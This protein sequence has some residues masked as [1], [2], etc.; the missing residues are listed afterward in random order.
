M[1]P[2]KNTVTWA[3]RLLLL[4]AP[5]ISSEG[6]AAPFSP[7]TLPGQ[8]IYQSDS[9]WDTTEGKKILLS[10]LKGAPVVVAM[11]YTGCQAACPMTISDLKRIESGLDPEARMQ[12]RFAIFSFDS[13]KD[14]PS[15]LKVFR[16]KHNLEPSRWSFFHGSPENVQELAALLGIRFKRLETGDFDHSNVI[17]VLD[18]QGVIVHRQIGLRIDPQET[19]GVI[20]GLTERVEIEKK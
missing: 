7:S 12:V 4:L 15:N 6:R 19:L 8:S 14:T 9:R 18:T 3:A 5:F 20:K 1:K 10:E 11:L 2:S 16:V 13:V 17:T